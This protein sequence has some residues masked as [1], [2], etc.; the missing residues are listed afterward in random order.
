M[1][2]GKGFKKVYN[3]SGGIKAW[4]GLKAAGPV[5]MG[6]SPLRGD[7]SP[8]EIIV[9]AYGMEKGLGDFYREM[10]GKTDDEEVIKVFKLLADVEEKHKERLLNLYLQLDENTPDKESFEVKTGKGLLEGGFTTDEFIEKNSKVMESINGVLDIAMMLETQSLDLYLRYSQKIGDE[11]AKTVLFDLAD[12]EK[13]HL[14][15][16]GD[17]IGKK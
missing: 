7:E 4:Q 5:D 1:L 11:K 15:S 16:L 2:A 10:A 6:L 3:L 13:V 8:I 12:E 17:L 9:L 14:V